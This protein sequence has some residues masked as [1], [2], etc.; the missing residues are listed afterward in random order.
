MLSDCI[1]IAQG[2]S[3]KKKKKLCKKHPYVN[4]QVHNDRAVWN[5]LEQN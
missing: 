2:Y 5:L 1:G 3:K 4:L